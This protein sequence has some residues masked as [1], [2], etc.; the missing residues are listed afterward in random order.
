MND[1]ISYKGSGTYWLR[2]I[3]KY[4]NDVTTIWCQLFNDKDSLTS[5]ALHFSE[6]NNIVQSDEW[7]NLRPE[8]GID[9][10]PKGSIPKNKGIPRTQQVKDAVSKANKGRLVG[11]NNPMY[12]KPR[13]DLV[14]RN[15]L[16][17]RWVT[18]GNVDKLILREEES[19]FLKNGW[20]IGRANIDRDALRVSGSK[21]KG[22]ISP[23]K[24]KKGR[25]YR[26]VTNGMVD[27]AVDYDM[28]EHYL[29]IGFIIGRSQYNNSKSD[30]N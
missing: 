7:A 27:H 1:P 29:S 12:G 4:G 3:R 26:W 30:K 5:Y 20:K 17:K 19:I 23:L 2:H 25:R 13:V 6:S 16:P 8:N 18:D 24:G 9:G 11:E 15:K 21:N 22:R 10:I 28:L 14:E